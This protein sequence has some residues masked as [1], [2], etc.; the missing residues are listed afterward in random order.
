MSTTIIADS[1]TMYQSEP[2]I[3]NVRKAIA[4][5]KVIFTI[6]KPEGHRPLPAALFNSEIKMG[7]IINHRV[8]RAVNEL[9]PRL[10]CEEALKTGRR[11]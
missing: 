11:I 4:S 9:D 2:E 7:L 6:V 3:C 1:P 5:D 10:T 8:D